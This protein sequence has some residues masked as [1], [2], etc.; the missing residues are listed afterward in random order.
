MFPL[1]VTG[2][3]FVLL[4]FCVRGDFGVRSFA[5]AMCMAVSGCAMGNSGAPLHAPMASKN[6]THVAQAR[7]KDAAANGYDDATQEVVF[8]GT[9]QDC[10]A[11]QAKAI[12]R[13]GV[14]N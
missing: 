12:T 7:M 2:D 3:N 11:W 8:Q 4:G 1:V 10:T 13:N 5:W 9:Y 14:V 6:C